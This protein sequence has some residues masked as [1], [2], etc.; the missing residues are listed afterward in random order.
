MI[1]VYRY[2]YISSIYALNI[3]SQ[4]ILL[5]S[6]PHHIK[7]NQSFFWSVPVIKYT[8]LIRIIPCQ[9]CTK[10]T[11]NFGCYSRPRLAHLIR[12]SSNTLS[13]LNPIKTS[14]TCP[15]HSLPSKLPKSWPRNSPRQRREPKDLQSAQGSAPALI[16]IG[17]LCLG[18]L[19]NAKLE[20]PIG[21]CWVQC[22]GAGK[23]QS[24]QH[25]CNRHTELQ[26]HDH[27]GVTLSARRPR[28]FRRGMPWPRT[29]ARVGIS[30]RH[31]TD[32]W[33]NSAWK[34]RKQDRFLLASLA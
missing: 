11:H 27:D 7:S 16:E 18:W 12:S 14:H 4:N 1:F 34:T 19:T 3:I 13:A 20:I 23:P 32:I 5:I 8:L 21:V 26:L 25:V 31:C 30:H 10:L 9:C 6:I 22:W 28:E 15:V 29:W 33:E 24:S 17:C 2:L